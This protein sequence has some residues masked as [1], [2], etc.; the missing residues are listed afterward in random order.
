M[1]P[2]GFGNL[3]RR[4][5]FLVL[6]LL[7]PVMS[8]PGPGDD[9]APD[10]P[11]DAEDADLDAAQSAMTSWI[12]AYQAGDFAAQWSLTDPRIRRWFDR[13]RWSN[14]L[15]RAFRRNGNL[16]EHAVT[17]RAA[18][19]AGQLPC[20]ELR[21]CFR[22]DVAYALFLLRTRYE[23]AAPPQPEF[24]VMARSGEGWRFGGGTLLNRPLGETAVIM[25]HEDERRYA[26]SYST[27]P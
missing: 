9:P 25:T 8:A 22:P 5:Q 21:H 4:R 16:I 13:R 11:D 3:I 12:G 20:S 18:V 23:I 6:C 14:S 15:K 26:P 27:R 24:C 10:W 7:A 1:L 2:A 17:D 19:S